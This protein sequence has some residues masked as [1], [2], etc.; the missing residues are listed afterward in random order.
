MADIKV[1]YLGKFEFVDSQRTYCETF[2]DDPM[3]F[4]ANPTNH[5]KNMAEKEL[6][7][8]YEFFMFDGSIHIIRKLYVGTDNVDDSMSTQ[9]VC[10]SLINVNKE[11]E[12]FYGKLVAIT[13][14][15]LFE[16]I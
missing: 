10:Q 6:Y 7:T 14:D 8:F 5:N 16:N 9:E 11:W 1:G 3:I 4:P 12:G 2:G 13:P 15:I